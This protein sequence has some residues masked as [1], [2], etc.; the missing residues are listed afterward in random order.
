MFT[1]KKKEITGKQ[2]RVRNEGLHNL[3]SSSSV[4]RGIKSRLSW[5]EHVACMGEMRNTYKI[6][7]GKPEVRI[8]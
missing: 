8:L 1:P 6:L 5:M 3:C 2:R 4:V 7:V